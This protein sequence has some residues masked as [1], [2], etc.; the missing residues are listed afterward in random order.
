MNQNTKHRAIKL[1]QATD[2]RHIKNVGV[3]HR[4]ISAVYVATT[5]LSQHGTWLKVQQW[6]I[7]KMAGY[8]RSQTK[9]AIKVLKKTGYLWVKHNYNKNKFGQSRRGVSS[10]GLRKLFAK[11]SAHANCLRSEITRSCTYS[12]IT[13]EIFGIPVPKLP[14]KRGL[15]DHIFD[16]DLDI[17]DY[18]P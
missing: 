16:G 17:M 3:S 11:F 10:M 6:R 1:A 18:Q 12:L 9:L 4:C 8:S 14:S 7:A 13:G 2:F 15:A 5:K